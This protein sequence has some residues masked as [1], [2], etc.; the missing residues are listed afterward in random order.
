MWEDCVQVHLIFGITSVVVGAVV[1]GFNVIGHHLLRT[2][3]KGFQIA[4]GF[5]IAIL[6]IIK[7]FNLLLLLSLA[8]IM[9]LFCF[10]LV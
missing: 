1:A 7:L 3:Y 2:V 4:N 6:V 10:V 5:L 9:K 8:V